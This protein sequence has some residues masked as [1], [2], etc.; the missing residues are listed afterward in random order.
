MS[1]YAYQTDLSI[2]I[3]LYDCVKASSMLRSCF[4]TLLGKAKQISMLQNKLQNETSCD[5]YFVILHLVVLSPVVLEMKPSSLYH[6]LK[7]V[8]SKYKHQHPKEQKA[9]LYSWW[10]QWCQH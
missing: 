1:V 9:R 2:R 5:E 3:L 6:F 10:Q 8:K 4:L 7:E